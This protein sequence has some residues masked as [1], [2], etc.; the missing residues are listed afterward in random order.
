MKSTKSVRAF[1]AFLWPLLRLRI[2]DALEVYIKRAVIGFDTSADRNVPGVV[3]KPDR[4]LALL[5]VHQPIRSKELRVHSQYINATEDGFH[6][7]LLDNS[8]RDRIDPAAI[9]DEDLKSF[10]HLERLCANEIDRRQY[11]LQLS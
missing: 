5:F 9:T 3:G 4:K 8:N 2:G 7:L 6:S 11:V 1:C 10:S